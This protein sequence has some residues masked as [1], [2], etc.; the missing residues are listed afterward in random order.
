MVNRAAH[1]IH[2]HTS[3]VRPTLH[4][5]HPCLCIRPTLHSEDLQLQISAHAAKIIFA[6]FFPL[7]FH[8]CKNTWKQLHPSAISSINLML[9]LQV[10][11]AQT[12]VRTLVS[13]LTHP[14]PMCYA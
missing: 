8:A 14:L 11:F 4:S 1:S 12:H 3:Y 7:D 5:T 2:S 10:L 6:T 9:L 13:P